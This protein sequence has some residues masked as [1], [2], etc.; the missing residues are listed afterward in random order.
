MRLQQ[1]S[2]VA[3][4]GKVPPP[5]AVLQVREGKAKAHG[6]GYG[7]SGFKFND[8]EEEAVKARKK[9]GPADLCSVSRHSMPALCLE[10]VSAWP[11][12]CRPVACRLCSHAL[13]SATLP[14]GAGP[15]QPPL[16][17]A[18]AFSAC[19]LMCLPVIPCGRCLPAGHEAQGS[20]E[21]P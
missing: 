11:A 2:A 3:P 9:V 19:K 10:T 7:G 6:S 21:P 14:A 4:L 12:G 20:M 13:A 18:S 16:L 17:A 8:Q 1:P 15:C 5:S